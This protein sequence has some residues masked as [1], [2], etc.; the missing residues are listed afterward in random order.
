MDSDAHASYQRWLVLPVA[1]ALLFVLFVR[2]EKLE[3]YVDDGTVRVSTSQF[4]KREMRLDFDEISE[5]EL[6]YV[7]PELGKGSKDYAFRGVRH[8]DYEVEGL[9][10]LRV[11]LDKEDPPYV[12]VRGRRSDKAQDTLWLLRLADEQATR[13]L[14]EQLRSEWKP[15]SR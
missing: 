6:L 3:V 7:M 14:F 15:P 9:G 11:V 1:A 8:G 4:H 12:F 10:K 13:D 5:I 2:T